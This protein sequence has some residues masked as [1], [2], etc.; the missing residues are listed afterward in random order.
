M[1]ERLSGEPL[2]THFG[3]ETSKAAN[4]PRLVVLRNVWTF[5]HHF[6]RVSSSGRVGFHSFRLSLLPPFLRIPMVTTGSHKH[7]YADR[8]FQSLTVQYGHPTQSPSPFVRGHLCSHIF[9]LCSAYDYDHPKQAQAKLPGTATS[10]VLYTRVMISSP[11]SSCNLV[12][13]CAQ[14]YTR[15]CLRP[16]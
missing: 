15:L 8:V 10:S 12:E 13:V 3:L 4:Y 5:I 14:Y 2:C 1:R 6:L 16:S 7:T 9:S 11:S